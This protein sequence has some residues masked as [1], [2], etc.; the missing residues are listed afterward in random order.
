M[1]ELITRLNLHY[2]RNGGLSNAQIAALSQDW[3]EDLSMYPMQIVRQAAKM[4]RND[5]ERK[6]FPS[7]GE[8][9][10]YCRLAKGDLDRWQARTALPS[11]ETSFEAVC[12][13]GLKRIAEIKA[14]L[15][16]RATA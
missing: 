14:R 13:T 1:A 16:Q 10:N 6:F 9:K 5:G 4:C 11:P 2:P 15:A 3:A 12:E 7:I 8:F